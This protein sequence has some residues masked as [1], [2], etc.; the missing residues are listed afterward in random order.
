MQLSRFYVR[1]RSW[2]RD[3][4]AAPSKIV[5][6][7]ALMTAN[8]LMSHPVYNAA[9]LAP[10]LALLWAARIPREV[11]RS[12]ATLLYTLV[13]LITL[14]WLIFFRE[15]PY[16]DV[17]GIGISQ[18]ALM[19]ALAM[20]FRFT[21]IVL[22]VPVLL[23]AMPQHE[24]VA[25]LRWLRMPFVV[26]HIVAMS[27]RFIPT[28]QALQVQVTDAQRSRG[29]EMDRVPLLQRVRNLVALLVPLTFLAIQH[30]EVLGK[31]LE[32]RGISNGVPKSF[33]R[34]PRVGWLDW[35][36]MGLAVFLLA[37]LAAG[38]YVYGLLVWRPAA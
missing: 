38:R 23:A 11:V 2:Y 35:V 25:G 14:S 13:P 33:Y 9:M 29:I 8:F 19:R 17:M 18:P 30:V 5:V 4:L 20:D 10:T 12:F 31:V 28:L 15:P 16:Y 36:C 21:A 37:A 26:A 6:P 7:L 3:R 22:T 34:R 32:M 1:R 24:I 27:L